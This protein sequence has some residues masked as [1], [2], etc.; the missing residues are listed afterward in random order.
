[1]LSTAVVTAIG[2]ALATNSRPP[3]SRLTQ[4]YKSGDQF[5]PAGREGID[6]EC[7][8]DQPGACTYTFDPDIG[9]YKPCRSGKFVL[10]RL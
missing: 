10:L 2:A 1:M 3:C 5:I 7:Q 6:Y 9:T 8:F 4:F